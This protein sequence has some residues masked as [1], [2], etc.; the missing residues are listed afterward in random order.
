MN[1][2]LS[3]IFGR[4]LPLGVFG[5]IAII[6]AELAFTG[7]ASG[8]HGQLDV[9]GQLYLLNR[10]LTLGFFTFLFVIYL[11]RGRAVAK[12]HNPVAVAAAMVGSFALFS[13]PLVPGRAPVRQQA[14]LVV[15]DLLLTAGILIALYSLS[16]LRRRFSLV[17]EARG[18]VRTG[19]YGVVRHP[20]YL[21]EILSGLGLVLP[22]AASPHL[23][24]FL[25]FLAAQLTRMRFEEGVLSRTY[26]EYQAYARATPRLI[27]FIY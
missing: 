17:P 9:A 21:G 26:P 15:S 2:R 18:L 11:L 16:Y 19:P 6:Q 3:Y 22:T 25:I 4:A 7:L 23:A 10:V 5:F 24:I 27:P 13:L 8:L 14:L 1:P 12:D 20:I